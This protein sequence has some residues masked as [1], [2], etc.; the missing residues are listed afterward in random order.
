MSTT[1]PSVLE[2]VWDTVSQTP[3]A[4]AAL[5]TAWG[6]W[7]SWSVDLGGRLDQ[8]WQLVMIASVVVAIGA[9]RIVR[10]YV[11]NAVLAVLGLALLGVLGVIAYGGFLAVGGAFEAHPVAAPFVTALIIA[12][13]ALVAFALFHEPPTREMWPILFVGLFVAAVFLIA[14]IFAA[15]AAHPVIMSVG[16]L[17]IS[18][19]ALAT[20]LWLV[21]EDY[22]S[23]GNWDLGWIPAV[24]FV[25]GIPAG[26]I[27][28]VVA[29]LVWGV[30]VAYGWLA[31]LFVRGD[32]AD[33]AAATHE[34][35]EESGDVDHTSSP[36][37]AD[38]DEVAT[39]HQ[40]FKAPSVIRPDD[41]PD[42]AS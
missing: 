32:E 14:A 35:E 11:W 40:M 5:G 26:L 18:T 4:A 28:A 6:G 3:Y 25:V 21:H 17:V 34:L 19:A 7:K 16:T 20:A 42:P 29:L 2:K 30:V 36:D 1:L 15:C 37:D 38:R 12:M 10:E 41:D 23:D 39:L 13:A 8:P 22:S 33:A 27:A 31:G 9:W 24:L